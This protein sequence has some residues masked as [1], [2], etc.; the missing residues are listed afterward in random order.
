M[1]RRIPPGIGLLAGS[2]LAIGIGLFKTESVTFAANKSYNTSVWETHGSVL[3]PVTHSIVTG[4]DSSGLPPRLESDA[5]A[6]APL[7][8]TL[9]LPERATVIRLTTEEFPAWQVESSPG[10][11]SWSM[12]VQLS[13]APDPRTDVASQAR[14]AAEGLGLGGGSVS[15][16][17][18][19]ALQ[20]GD[21]PARIIWARGE[22]GE[23]RTLAG[24][25]LVDRGEGVFVTLGVITSPE[26]FPAVESLLD[27]CFAT[28]QL[29][30]PAEMMA[31]RSRSVERAQATLAA[32]TP[33]RLKSL[34]HRGSSL[35]RIWRP[36][37]NEQEEMGW[38]EM[39]VRAGRR[40]DAS[41]SGQE[42]A[43]PSNAEEGL[44]VLLTARMNSADGVDRVET[45]ARYWM[46]WDMAAEAWSIRSVQKGSGPEVRFE[47]LGLRPRLAGGK[48]GDT[49]IVSTQTGGTASEPQEYPVPPMAYLPQALTLV[50]GP[51]LPRDP[52]EAG[53]RIFYALDP[54]SGRMC[55]RP[56]EWKSNA[57]GTWTLRTRANPE[58][59]F[60]TEILDAT[61]PRR[62]R[63]EPDGTRTSISNTEEIRKRWQAMG[64]EP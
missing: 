30:D 33:E 16:L 19:R 3:S 55:Q 26:D 21:R 32:L 9:R 31:E 43:D 15:V 27:A 48:A 53:D 35:H 50:L 1:R 58:S 37:G 18:D 8:L 52:N 54:G 51:V 10:A 61:G 47:Q 28:A 12:R 39:A 36:R 6:F 29:R 25:M 4:D 41:L 5:F 45:V 20:V 13:F 63:I 62:E 23:Q 44:L 34:V 11:P 14:A 24:W 46:S 40:G 42:T 17:S 57:D 7:G 49:L 64:L 60:V 22:R 59:N 38:L 2:A 56:T